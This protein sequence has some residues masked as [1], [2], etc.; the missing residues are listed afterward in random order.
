VAIERLAAG[1]AFHKT[2]QLALLTGLAGAI[3]FPERQWRLVR[4][5]S[6]RGLA[7]V[8]SQCAGR[9]IACTAIPLRR[10]E[11]AGGGGTGNDRFRDGQKQLELT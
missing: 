3:G 6:R 8:A 2:V 1:R 7:P 5:G 4:G 9:P 11:S 10:A